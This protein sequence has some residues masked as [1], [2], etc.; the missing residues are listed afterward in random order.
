[1]GRRWWTGPGFCRPGRGPII[2]SCSGPR[3]GPAHQV[4]IRSAATGSVRRDPARPTK[5]FCQRMG[6]GPARPSNFQRMGRGPARP[7]QFSRGWAAAGPG[8]SFCLEDGPR[9]DP[10][11]DICSEAQKTRALCG[12]RPVDLKGRPMCYPVQERAR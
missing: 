2:F 8:A 1:M 11:H 10:A 4:F 3:P 6:R 12:P 9:P 7:H 5:F